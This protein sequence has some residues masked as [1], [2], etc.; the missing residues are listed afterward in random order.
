VIQEALILA[1]AGFL[2]GLGAAV[3]M[4]HYAGAATRLPLEMTPERV[5]LVFCVTLGMCIISATIA[6]RKVQ[7]ADPADVF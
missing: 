7:S 5:I 4:Y 2:P 6:L 1:V 3:V